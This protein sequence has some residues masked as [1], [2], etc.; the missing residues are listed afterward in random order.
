MKKVGIL[1]LNGN[2][3]YGNKLQNYATIKVLES[4]NLS[5]NTIWFKKRL[6]TKIKDEIKY[7][8]PV[9]KKDVR[10]RKF[11][12]FTRMHLKRIYVTNDKLNN[13]FDHF[14]VGSDQV[15]NYEFGTFTD[16]YFLP[17]SNREKNIA[18]SAS[19]GVNKISPEYMEKFKKGLNNFKFISVR[20]DAGKDIVDTM[21]QNENTLVLIDPTMMLSA[22]QWDVIAR[23]PTKSVPDKYI[24]NYFL[25][26]FTEERKQ[27]IEKIALEYKCKVINLLDRDSDFYTSGP[28]E[29]L[30]LEKNAFLIC[31]DSFH[32]SVFAIIYNRPFVVFSRKEQELSNMDSRIETL[33]SKFKLKNR[34]YEKQITKENLNHDYS[35]AY[36]ILK[37]EREKTLKF[38]TKATTDVEGEKYGR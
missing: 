33:I 26:D 20:E 14:I 29:F 35:Y 18:Y 5:P 6:K 36:E 23:K 24:L 2:R 30:Y 32:A 4:I 22:N 15:W 11:E 17:F 8:F 37:N 25:G 13:R 19:F 38:L 34:K 3:N 9:R 7:I 27:E 31:T 12:K 28:S 1:T 10:C 16:D 21:V